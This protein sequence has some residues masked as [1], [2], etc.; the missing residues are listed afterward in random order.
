M[1]TGHIK[2]DY[3]TFMVKFE[4]MEEKE[5][6]LFESQICLALILAAS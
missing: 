4:I 5:F 3:I 2:N 1:T 6:P